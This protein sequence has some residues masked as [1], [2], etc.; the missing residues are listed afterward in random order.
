[1]ELIFAKAELRDLFVGL[2]EKDYKAY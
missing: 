2:M 1:M